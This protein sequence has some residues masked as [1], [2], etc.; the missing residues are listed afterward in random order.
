MH[1]PHKSGAIPGRSHA[2][3]SGKSRT[4][5]EHSDKDSEQKFLEHSFA[6]DVPLTLTAILCM[7]LRK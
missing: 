7:G 2:R 1:T 4:A 6:G 5:D 3:R